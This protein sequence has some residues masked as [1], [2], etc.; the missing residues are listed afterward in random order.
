MVLDVLKEIFVFVCLNN[1][2]TRLTC[3]PILLNVARLI[4]SSLLCFTS[5]YFS[6]FLLQAFITAFE[7]RL[8]L[9][10]SLFY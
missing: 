3:I 6:L 5:L 10:I 9:T 2:L 8:L 1:L 7:Y 4:W